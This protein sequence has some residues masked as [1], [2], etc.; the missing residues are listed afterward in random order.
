MSNEYHGSMTRIGGNTNNR[1]F[2]FIII[3]YSFCES[4]CEEPLRYCVNYLG[5]FYAMSLSQL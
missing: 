2:D 5:M 1:I 3:W 4:F